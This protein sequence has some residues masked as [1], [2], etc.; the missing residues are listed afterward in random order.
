MGTT[1]RSPSA[2]ATTATPF[3]GQGD[4]GLGIDELGIR[5]GQ[6]IGPDIVLLHPIESPPRQRGDIGAHHRFESDITGFG[7]Q[8]R[9]ET[10]GRSA[11]R[12]SLHSGG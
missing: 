5:L 2:E 12:A 3:L 1:K 4:G 7:E 6:G 9:T 10:H 11:A 8:H